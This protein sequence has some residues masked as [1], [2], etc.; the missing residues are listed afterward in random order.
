MIDGSRFGFHLLILPLL[1]HDPKDQVSLLQG[2]LVFPAAVSLV[3][4]DLGVFGSSSDSTKGANIWP[5][6]I[7]AVIQFAVFSDSFIRGMTKR[8]IF[9]DRIRENK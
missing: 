8:E 3:C 1:A 6:K 9:L 7:F 2:L 5:S 4:Q